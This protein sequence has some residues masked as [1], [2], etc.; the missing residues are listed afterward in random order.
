[1]NVFLFLF[2]SPF[3]VLPLVVLPYSLFFLL[4]LPD[5]VGGVLPLLERLFGVKGH[6]CCLR[7]WLSGRYDFRRNGMTVLLY[8]L[9]Y[10]TCLS[11]A[12]VTLY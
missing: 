10:F 2:P 6:D 3:F 5:P 8:G 9:K 7:V 12:G 11:S 4:I 1:M